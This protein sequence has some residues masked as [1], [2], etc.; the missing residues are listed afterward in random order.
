MVFSKQSLGT[1][2]YCLINPFLLV[3]V[4]VNIIWDAV[5][6]SYWRSMG[7]KKGL[8]LESLSRFSFL[9]RWLKTWDICGNTGLMCGIRIFKQTFR[10]RAMVFCTIN[11]FPT[12]GNLSGYIVK[13]YHACPICERNKSFIQLKHG[14]KIIYT[15]HQRFL[16]RYHPYRRLKKN[17]MIARRM[18]VFIDH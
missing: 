11:Y 17:L 4:D 3:F 12:Y 2:F 15:R 10:L 6:C 16:K 14:K 9:L 18:K 7:G 8:V 5:F 1:L 13:G